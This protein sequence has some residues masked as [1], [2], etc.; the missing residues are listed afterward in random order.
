MLYIYESSL[1]IYSSFI[2][3]ASAFFRSEISASVSE[4]ALKRRKGKFTSGEKPAAIFDPAPIFGE[5]LRRKRAGHRDTRPNGHPA[6]RGLAEP[7]TQRVRGCGPPRLKIPPRRE[8]EPSP[9]R[10]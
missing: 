9:V 1:G 5:P 4:H 3:R 6:A 8:S 10:K 2:H 7:A